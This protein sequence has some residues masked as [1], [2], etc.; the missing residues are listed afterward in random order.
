[1]KR[2]AVVMAGGHGI[3]FWPRST[4]K[5]PKQ[6]IHLLGEG[7]M[8]QNTVSRLQ[9]MF[10]LE[11]MYIVTTEPMVELIKDQLPAIP[12]ENIIPEPFGRN[13]APCL[14]LTNIHLHEKYGDD[15]TF[16]AFPSDHNIQNVGEFIQSLEIA[17]KASEETNGIVTIGIDP[18]RAET[19]YGYV[20]VN[21]NKRGIKELFDEGL[22]KCTTFAEKPDEATAR[23]FMESGDFLWNSGIFVMKYE[24]F[25]NCYSRYLP[26]ET[27]L[28]SSLIKHL[29]KDTYP[30]K[31]DN[32]YRQI[33]SISFDYAVMEKASDVYVV[34]SS[35]IWSDMGT[36][37]E[38]FRMSRKDARN[39]VI[40][41][42]VIPVNT[43]NC[44]VSSSGRLIGIV[45]VEDLIVID[46]EDAVLIC[47]RGASD[48]VREIIDFM[49]RKN[50][51]HLL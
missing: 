51:N 38:L 34:E 14:G 7:T 5:L 3:R 47:R 37:D 24:T 31:L 19:H 18:T 12:G 49:R 11:D 39:N 17:F 15:F 32:V 1:M 33:N 40:E 26:E 28:F 2:V 25:R 35:F 41:G 45:N 48:D 36:W 4:E 27:A 10:E 23:R 44:L 22:R 6:F 13:T 8:I 9:K 20:Q 30:D 50:I 46:S 16:A 43:S 21:N 29:G 42:D